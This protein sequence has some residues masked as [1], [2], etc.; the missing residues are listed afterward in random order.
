[1]ATFWHNVQHSVSTPVSTP[2]VGLGIVNRVIGWF[3]N[4]QQEMA[5][6]D[7]LAQLDA[8]DL[9]DL[10]ISTSDF[11]AIAHGTYRR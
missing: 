8:R 6:R 3:R 1:M 7:E 2:S 11:D 9:H 5:V 4:L 10:G